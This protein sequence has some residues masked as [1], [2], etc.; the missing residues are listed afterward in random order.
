MKA[1]I[2]KDE[3]AVSPVIATILMVAITVV[4]AAVLY[5]MVSG[6]ITTPTTPSSGWGINLGKS[7]DASNWTLSFTTIPAST[8]LTN[9]FITVTNPAG[10]ALVSNIPLSQIASSTTSSPN[11]GYQYVYLTP[12]ST[13]APPN[14]PLSAGDVVRLAVNHYQTGCTVSITAGSSVVYTHALQ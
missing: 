4:L 6:L 10:A 13:T 3:D 7:G 5:V 1:I 12:L 2:R 9:V 11:G 8:L 14:T